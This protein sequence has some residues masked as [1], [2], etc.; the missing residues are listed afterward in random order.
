M[1]DDDEESDDEDDSEEGMEDGEG[2]FNA[3]GSVV[4]YD[5]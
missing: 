2:A 1:T 5:H 3:V 4:Y